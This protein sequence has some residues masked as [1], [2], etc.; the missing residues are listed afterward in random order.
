LTP[1]TVM[2]STLA[3]GFATARQ[4]ARAMD[5]WHDM[6]S[7]GIGANTVVCNALI[8]AQARNGCIDEITQIVSAMEKDGCKPDVITFSTITKGYC[9]KGDLD[10]AYD[11]LISTQENGLVTDAIIYNT[12]LDGCL[13][14]NR[15]DLADLLV[16][17]MEKH[18]ITPSNFTLGILVKMYG[19]RHQLDKAFEITESVAT[20][21]GLETNVQVKMSLIAACINNRAIDRALKVFEELKAQNGTDYK[22]YGVMI[23]GC[24]RYRRLV[25]AV[26]FVE[27]A[28]GVQDGARYRGLPSGQVLE[29]DRLEQL[30]HVLA[31]QDLMKSIGHPLLKKLRDAKVPDVSRLWLLAS[32]GK[33]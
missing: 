25:E 14:H 8:D 12:V 28:Y 33:A 22:A 18:S 10:K 3:K 27:E 2:Y 20:R 6:R 26:A 16:A 21:H 15:P 19:R 5:L 11:V 23:A 24:V 31:Q 29:S 17:D 30:L 9:V 7:R 13:R 1:N 32:Q 4:S